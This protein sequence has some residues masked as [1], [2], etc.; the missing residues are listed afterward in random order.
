MDSHPLIGVPFSA[1]PKRQTAFCRQ[2][3]SLPAGC[4]LASMMEEA[5]PTPCRRTGFHIRI[6][7]GW[8]PGPI[9]SISPGDAL[10]IASWI[11]PIPE[12]VSGRVAVTG[13][14]FLPP[15]VTV[16]VSTDGL[17]LAAVMTSSPQL[18]GDAP[19][20]NRACCCTAQ[21]GTPPGT[22]DYDLPSAHTK[23]IGALYDRRRSHD[24]HGA[25]TCPKA[26]MTLDF[27]LVIG[28]RVS[29]TVQHT[30]SCPQ[31]WSPKAVMVSVASGRE[32]RP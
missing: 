8:V 21:Y 29:R 14:G 13:V 10:S 9:M 6:I 31:S 27:L 32:G 30:R 28:R 26:V 18:C 11:D 17:P 22:S 7:S 1:R 12:A 16:T 4:V 2:G 25:G 5:A 3:F 24:C 20:L 23:H 15:M 19:L